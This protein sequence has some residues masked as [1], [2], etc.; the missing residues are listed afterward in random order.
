[1]QHPNGWLN[2]KRGELNLCATTHCDRSYA[3]RCIIHRPLTTP[4]IV[5]TVVVT[6]T[7]NKQAT[8]QPRKKNGVLRT[9]C[10]HYDTVQKRGK[11]G[12]RTDV[13]RLSKERD[14]GKANRITQMAKLCG[15]IDPIANKWRDDG[16][17]IRA[18]LFPDLTAECPG[19]GLQFVLLRLENCWDNT[20]WNTTRKS[21]TAVIECVHFARDH[22]LKE[23]KEDFANGSVFRRPKCIFRVNESKKLIDYLCYTYYLKN[24]RTVISPQG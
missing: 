8:W 9:D 14:V 4:I 11:P 18:S 1:M 6:T 3:Q 5:L 17:Y 21:A 20:R 2:A 15:L 22:P 12:R 24:K 19:R 10:Q 7:I 16:R 23:R 13:R